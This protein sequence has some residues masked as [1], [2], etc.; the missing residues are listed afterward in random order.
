MPV[1]LNVLK[2]SIYKNSSPK[3]KER[4]D[5]MTQ[6]HYFTNKVLIQNIETKKF[7]EYKVY[8]TVGEDKQ[9]KLFWDLDENK[10]PLETLHQ[11]NDVFSKSNNSII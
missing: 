8:I 1:L 11:T 5:K 2:T 10:K 6:F 9:G 3:Y 7:N 4:R